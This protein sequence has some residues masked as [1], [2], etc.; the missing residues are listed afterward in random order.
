MRALAAVGRQYNPFSLQYLVINTIL[1]NIGRYR[2]LIKKKISP[3]M[4]QIVLDSA[5]ENIRQIGEDQVWAALPYLDQHRTTES[6]STIYFASIFHLKGKI[7]EID[8]G[9]VSME[10]FLQYLIEFVPNL[11]KLKILDPRWS[12]DKSLERKLFKKKANAEPYGEA[13]NV[14]LSNDFLDIVPSGLTKLQ[15]TA[16]KPTDILSERNCLLRNLCSVGGTLKMLILENIAPELN[17][18]LQHI[19]EHCHELETLHIIDS[20][21]AHD[22]QIASFG[23]LKNFKWFLATK[24]V[25]P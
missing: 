23:K 24:M 16:Q 25:T 11:Q 1:K 22:E 15:I 9:R 10:E 8:E 5:M 3:P 7:G 14:T 2:D 13:K 17:I 19:F 18:T 12:Y 4:R 6:F 20:R 21:I